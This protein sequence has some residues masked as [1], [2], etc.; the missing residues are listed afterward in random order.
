MYRTRSTAI[1]LALGMVLFVLSLSIPGRA[2]AKGRKKRPENQGQGSVLVKK[3]KAYTLTLQSRRFAQGNAILAKLS[4]R[5]E[6]APAEAP[7]ILW[8]NLSYRLF[9][10]DD[11]Y[12]ALIPVSP[13]LPP[14]VHALEVHWPA[15][16]GPPDVRRYDLLIR[17]TR[18]QVRPVRSLKVPDQYTA[19]KLPKE[20]QEFIAECRRLREQAFK[21]ESPLMLDGDFV[22]PVQPAIVTS[23]FY[24][25][26]SYNDRG[27]ERPHGGTDFQGRTGDPV[28]ATQAGRVLIARPM[29]YEGTFTVLDH[30]AQVYSFYMHQSEVLVQEGDYV[31]KG[32]RIGRI[33]TTGVSTGPHLHFGVRIKDTLVD[34][35]SLL[36]LK[37]H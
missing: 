15:E 27:Q 37:L 31:Q 24:L 6:A 16:S 20:T 1:P 13:E 29:Y 26:R 10:T 23:P 12:C 11:Q 17:K 34:P 4:P 19:P 22:Y 3:E 7:R 35:L 5:A 25:R 36:A 18:F 32:A 21:T 33:G 9:R 8:Q 2:A 28:Y 30:G 14:G